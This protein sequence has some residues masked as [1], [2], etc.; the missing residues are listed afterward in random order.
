VGCAVARCQDKSINI[1]LPY[2]NIGGQLL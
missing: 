1:R 2:I